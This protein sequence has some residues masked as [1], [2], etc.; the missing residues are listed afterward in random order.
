M[1]DAPEP[2]NRVLV[3]NGDY[4][5]AIISSLVT[6]CICFSVVII[7]GYVGQISLVQNALAGI[8]AFMVT[9]IAQSLGIGFPFGLILAALCAVVVGVVIGLPAV[10][11]RGV[12]LA[13]TPAFSRDGK[14]VAFDGWTMN[15]DAGVA[16]GKTMW[17]KAPN[18]VQPSMRAA[19]SSSPGIVS[20]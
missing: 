6:A 20:K 1:L 10:R 18:R 11:V 2:I 9:H 8:S 12:N 16:S 14:S 3:A 19:S 13:V 15:S 4:R 17:K 5:S 7:T